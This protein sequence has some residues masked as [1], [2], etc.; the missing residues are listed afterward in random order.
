MAKLVDTPRY[1]IPLLV[2]GMLALLAGLWGGLLRLGWRL[3]PLQP[4]LPI[5]H[6]PLMVCGF[7]G[8][9]IGLERAV[10]LERL[11]AFAAPLMAGLGGL[12]LIGG[13]GTWQGPAL[14][15]VSSLLLLSIFGV[16]L[17]IQFQTFLI[18]MAMG[19]AAWFTGNVLW[20]LGAPVFQIVGWWTGFLVLTIAGERLDLS[21]ML[22]H[23]PHVQPLFLVLVG[24]LIAGLGLTYFMPGLGTRLTG[25]AFTLLALWLLR[26]DIAR[27]TVRQVGLTRF[28][29]VCLIAGYVWLIVGGVLMLVYGGLPGGPAYDALLHAIFV[30]FVFSMIFGHAPII[31]PALL[32]V[33]MT[34]G[35][36]FYAHLA[37]LH[38][39]LVMRVVGDLGGL[40]TLRLWGGLLNTAAIIL[41]LA[42][43]V[44]GFI[45]GSRGR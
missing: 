18:V 22:A 36:H 28:I 19:A 44:H 14:I 40:F 32:G 15:T 41:F 5:M 11:W 16:V 25:G 37:L 21:R 33:R 34:Y 3:D 1:R 45:S 30:G 39:S 35:S 17:R 24:L 6:G 20:L 2:L 12:L 4:M 43:T 10:A 29:A 9:V 7:L 26:Y 38:V 8:T 42:M 13:I 27:Q 23:A 31:F